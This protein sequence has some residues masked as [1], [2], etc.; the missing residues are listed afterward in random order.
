MQRS[1]KWLG[2]LFVAVLLLLGLNSPLQADDSVDISRDPFVVL[3]QS[4]LDE[5]NS[6]VVAQEAKY[7]LAAHCFQTSRRLLEQ[8]AISL[9]EYKRDYVAMKVEEAQVQVFKQR[10]IARKAVL[11]VVILNRLAGREVQQCI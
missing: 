11:D 8:Q 6:E 10:V 1:E 7:N 5:A 3:F 4:K 9:D 2:N